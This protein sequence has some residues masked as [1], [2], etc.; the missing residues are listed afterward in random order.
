MQLIRRRSSILV[1]KHLYV[2]TCN[3]WYNT[4]IMKF[5]PRVLVHQNEALCVR[6]N[7]P[8]GTLKTGG[9]FSATAHIMIYIYIY[10]FSFYIRGTGNQTALYS[11]SQRMDQDQVRPLLHFENYA[12]C[13]ENG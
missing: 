9:C 7:S 5:Q 4:M 6:Q 3:K 1:S 13:N 12:S 8:Q 2:L 11:F 10:Y